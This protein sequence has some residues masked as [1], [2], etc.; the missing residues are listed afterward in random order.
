MVLIIQDAIVFVIEC[1]KTL[2]KNDP[3]ISELTLDNY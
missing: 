2:L 3:A 1:N